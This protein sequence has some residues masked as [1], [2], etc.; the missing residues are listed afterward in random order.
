L[1]SAELIV[2]KCLTLPVSRCLNDTIDACLL[3]R[4]FGTFF[5]RNVLG[6]IIANEQSLLNR[7]HFS[8]AST[9]STYEIGRPSH[10]SVLIKI[11]N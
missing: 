8:R 10:V 4:N 11:P 9:T 1:S 5:P 3:D 6:K 7:K 2:Q